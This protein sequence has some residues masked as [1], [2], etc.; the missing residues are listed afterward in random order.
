MII[1]NISCP[2]ACVISQNVYFDIFVCS[3]ILR[4]QFQYTVLLSLRCSKTQ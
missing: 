2:N 4:D 3:K 1:G